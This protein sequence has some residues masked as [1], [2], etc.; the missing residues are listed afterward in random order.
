MPDT[1]ARPSRRT[2]PG[3]TGAGAMA[4]P[5]AAPPREVRLPEIVVGVLLVAGCAL[6]ALIWQRSQDSTTTIVVA[7]RAI[8]RG[9]VI[10]AEHLGGARVGGET[11]GLI[12]GDAAG[13]LLGETAQIDIAAGVPLTTGASMRSEPLRADE[14]LIGLALEPGQAPNGLEPLDVVRPIVSRVDALGQRDSIALDGAATVWSVDLDSTAAPMVVTLRAPV[15]MLV[16]LVG[17]A[18]VHLARIGDAS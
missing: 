2:R 5:P 6:G 14:A 7:A 3:S 4:I 17:A 12:A 11:S 8:P 18:E 13:S 1:L 16:D 10:T 15:S 9:T